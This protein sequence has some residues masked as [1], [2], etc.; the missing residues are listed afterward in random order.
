MLS[1]LNQQQQ[2]RCVERFLLSACSRGPHVAPCLRFVGARGRPSEEFE[3]RKEN[4][5]C[6]AAVPR[7]LVL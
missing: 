3:I 5:Q 1:Q 2:R 7:H 6:E 4:D